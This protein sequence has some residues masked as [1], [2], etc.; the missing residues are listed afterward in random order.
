MGF[1]F[2]ASVQP[3]AEYL[4]PEHGPRPPFAKEEAKA[5]DVELWSTPEPLGTEVVGGVTRNRWC[6]WAGGSGLNT[7]AGAA[8]Q[9]G[10]DYGCADLSGVDPRHEIEWFRKEYAEALGALTR[11]FGVGPT[12]RWGLVWH[13]EGSSVVIPAARAGG[14][15]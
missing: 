10:C 13:L 8:S 2:N 5:G 6:F 15:A 1:S 14:G 9:I 12:I 3:Y 4:V 11:H 7:S